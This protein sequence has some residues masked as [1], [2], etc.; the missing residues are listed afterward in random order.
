MNRAICF[1]GHMK[2]VA[3]SGG[4]ASG[5]STIARR[6]ASLGAV[7]VDADQ[8]ARDAVEIGSSGLARIRAVFG[9][10]VLAEDGGL[11]RAK[12]AAMVFRDADRLAALNEI[13][14]PEVRRLFARRLTEIENDDPNAIVIYDVPL[15]AE[16]E[17]RG[18]WDLVIMAEAPTELR[19]DRMVRLRGM[20]RGEAEHRIANQADDDSRRAIADVII[21]T[22]GSEAETL[23]QVDA[24]WARFTCDGTH[25]SNRVAPAQ[26]TQ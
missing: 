24:L 23:E 20:T 11:D 3:L 7:H 26:P 16:A 18:E 14:H 19:I 12:L 25:R 9:E 21:D 8:L 15:L 22:S 1:D 2:L 6:F 10:G 4:I 17:A 5:K 13:V